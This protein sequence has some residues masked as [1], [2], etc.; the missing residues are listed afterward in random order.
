MI[1]FIDESKA[2]KYLLV[3]SLLESRDLTTTRKFLAQTLLAG[4]RSVHF[5]KESPRRRTYLIK[6]FRK[7]DIR[8]VVFKDKLVSSVSSRALLI[9]RICDEA[10]R[11]ALRELVFELDQTCL[12]DDVALLNV[13]RPD[14]SWDHRE[15]NQEPLL[16]VSDAV[17]WCVNRGGEWERMVRPMIVETIEC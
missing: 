4:Q 10:K 11:L 13:L 7:L 12:D 5:R 3:L 14:L 17:A 15:R 2:K 1:A 9:R 8:V 16:W 6:T